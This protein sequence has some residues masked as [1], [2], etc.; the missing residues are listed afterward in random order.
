MLGNPDVLNKTKTALFC[1]TR[2][3]GDPI[4]A[5]CDRAARWRDPLRR[6]ASS[7]AGSVPRTK[8]NGFASSLVA[9]SPLSSARPNYLE[10]LRRPA[11]MD[12]SEPKKD[13]G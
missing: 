12:S 1:S 3:P 5:V 2:C 13:G 11:I 7:S 4:L 8:K 10:G 6:T 9:N